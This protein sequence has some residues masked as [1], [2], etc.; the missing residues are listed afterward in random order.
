M[1]RGNF[2]HMRHEMMWQNAGVGS[3]LW[4]RSCSVG[5]YKHTLTLWQPAFINSLYEHIAFPFCSVAYLEPRC[6]QEH[7]LRAGDVL[8]GATH[9][10]EPRPPALP[11][12]PP[13]FPPWASLAFY[14]CIYLETVPQLEGALC[15]TEG[16]SL[17]LV[18]SAFGCVFFGVL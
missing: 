6:P 5:M 10:H 1:P 16:D 12:V 9:C 3:N 17:Q 13:L 7:L 11:R 14:Q 15:T 4:R 2:L 8:P 18:A